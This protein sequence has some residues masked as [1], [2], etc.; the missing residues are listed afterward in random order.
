MNARTLNQNMHKVIILVLSIILTACAFNGQI[1]GPKKISS[2]TKEFPVYTFM[3]TLMFHLPSIGNPIVL[4]NKFGDT[5]DVGYTTEN[6][7]FNS[8]S[9][10][11]LNGWFFKPNA[12]TPAITL[13]H[14]HGAGKHMGDH[15]KYIS[16][17]LKNG[18]QV[19]MFDY[20]G[21]GF[22]QG[23]ASRENMVMDILSAITYLKSRDDVENTKLVTYGQSLGAYYS[24]VIGPMAQNDIDGMVVE[25]P[26]TSFKEI[27]GDR[28]PIIGNIIMKQGYQAEKS[29]QGYHKPLLLIHSTEDDEAPFWMGKKIFDNANHPKQ[30]YEIKKCHCCGPRYYS[31]EISEKIYTMFDVDYN[32]YSYE[33]Y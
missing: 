30:F 8:S 2:T 21:F 24:T 27:A 17:L 15:Y 25:S 10:N 16:P 4:T 28:I 33:D 20:S 7:F 22:S 3:D 12:R 18:F 9:G 14:L 29:I 26:I 13:L 19:L 6:V 1:L 11:T 32:A 5:L 23:E 31:D